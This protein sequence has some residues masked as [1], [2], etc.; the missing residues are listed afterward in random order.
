MPA[1]S[2][3]DPQGKQK[4]PKKSKL[5]SIVSGAVSGVFVSAVVQPLDVVRTRM[6]ADV[7][8]GVFL[9]TA[10]TF[11]TVVAEVRRVEVCG[12]DVRSYIA[13]GAAA[14]QMRL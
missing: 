2:S 4:K 1:T 10:R 14:A 11:R 12:R 5:A 13:W 9:S 8:K 3:E 7:A 6:Q